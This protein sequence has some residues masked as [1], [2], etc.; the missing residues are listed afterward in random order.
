MEHATRRPLGTFSVLFRIFHRMKRPFVFWG[1]G[2]L[3]GLET[4][5]SLMAPVLLQGLIRSVSHEGSAALGWSLVL[6]AALWGLYPLICL[7]GRRCKRAVRQGVNALRREILGHML[8]LPYDVF[9]RRS[10]GEYT[11]L[12]TTD[13]ERATAFLQGYTVSSLFRALL[14]LGA[15][16]GVLLA[17]SPAMLA[18]GL[19]LAFLSWAF[20]A[21]LYPI[22]Q[23]L[24]LSIQKRLDESGD[25]ISQAFQGAA[26]IRS[27]CLQPQLT[28]QYGRLCRRIFQDRVRLKL[29]DAVIN[30]W[31]ELAR[32]SAQPL[33]LAAGAWAVAR[34]VM[35]LDTLVLTSGYVGILAEAV[36]SLSLFAHNS[37]LSLASAKR[38]L[39]LLDLPGEGRDKGSSRYKKSGDAPP[40]IC[41]DHVSF[42]YPGRPPLL[43]H[44]CLKIPEGQIWGIIGGSGCGKSTLLKL[45]LGFYMPTNG[46]IRI[47]GQPIETMNLDTLRGMT[48]Y[49]S[50]DATLFQ[51]SILDNI[52]WGRPEANDRQ[53]KEAARRAKIHDFIDTLPE[54]YH[55]V[56]ADG[57]QNI[58]GGQ[59]QRIALARA[60]LKDAP[61]LLLD[62]FTSALD[63]ETER[64]I[65]D[66][67]KAIFQG[68]TVLMIA[69]RPAAL[70][71]ADE[72][73]QMQNGQFRQ[74]SR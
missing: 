46:Q 23:R 74:V 44:A 19:M 13:T 52:R 15:S 36:G 4:A 11:A 2:L 43:D 68:K 71:I 47:K 16:I 5:G 45:L 53:V 48:A 35:A 67:L 27:F 57:A 49:V 61:I 25:Q 73:I 51:A 6:A 22:E 58:S 26:E 62:E 1:S 14:L 66:D 70:A 55:T 37:Q 72:I 60:I 17:H 21:L 41:F 30:G 54:G 33:A 7:G 63:P 69:H 20:P 29:V 9:R 3:S 34:G 32:L 56:I 28:E 8:S 59:R 40:A 65:I 38:I 18:L 12:L 31:I 24:R 50:Q 10:I 64:A 39:S 42:A